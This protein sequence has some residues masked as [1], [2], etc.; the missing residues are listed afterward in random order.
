MPPG[1]VL[2]G[3]EGP[4]PTVLRLLEKFADLRDAEKARDEANR[5]KDAE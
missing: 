2:P 1:A 5:K 3:G 4:V